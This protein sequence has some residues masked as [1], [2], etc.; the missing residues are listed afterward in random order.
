MARPHL[1]IDER[2]DTPIS[3]RLTDEVK[4]F[5]E[6]E[7]RRRDVPRAIVLREIVVAWTRKEM[8]ERR[9]RFAGEM[10]LD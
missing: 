4:A 8:A 5:V 7:A 1:P 10:L 9:K 6:A 2:H 3:I